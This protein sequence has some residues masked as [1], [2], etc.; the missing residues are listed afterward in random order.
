M[1][2][3]KKI[4]SEDVVSLIYKVRE[5]IPK[6]GVRYA[7]ANR[8]MSS[9]MGSMPYTCPSAVGNLYWRMVNGLMGDGGAI[10]KSWKIWRV[11]DGF[12]LGEIDFKTYKTA[13]AADLKE[14][15]D[16]VEQDRCNAPPPIA[17]G[18]QRCK[19]AKSA[20]AEHY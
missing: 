1:T 19:C 4:S 16:E 11:L 10:K 3:C 20:R 18:R 9:V 17:S 6:T 12:F 13:D 14:P 5:V 7:D 15:D 8:V 2:E